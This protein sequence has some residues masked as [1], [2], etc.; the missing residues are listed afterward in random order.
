MNDNEKK[1]EALKPWKPERGEEYFTIEN[2]VDVVRYI[3][4]EMIL[5]NLVSYPATTFRQENVSNKSQRK[6]GCCY[7]WN[8]CMI[9]FARIMCQTTKM[10]MK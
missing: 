2:G 7:G 1:L 10:M 8:S 6:C 4:I 3:Y 9:C 5:T